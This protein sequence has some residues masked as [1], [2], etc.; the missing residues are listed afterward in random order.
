MVRSP[1]RLVVE[2]GIRD[3][4]RISILVVGVIVLA[5]SLSSWAAPTGS[6]DVRVGPDPRCIPN[7]VIYRNESGFACH[8][9]GFYWVAVGTH[10]IYKRDDECNRPDRI[11][12]DEYYHPDWLYDTYE[13][14]CADWNG[15][16]GCPVPACP[17]W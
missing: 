4:T 12:C 5:V 6:S 9:E 7:W 16:G 2:E 13:E 17:F 3:M 15:G 14:C 11:T 1:A 10:W 8:Q